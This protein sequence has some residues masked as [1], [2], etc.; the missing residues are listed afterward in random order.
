MAFSHYKTY[1]TMTSKILHVRIGR[2]RASVA[3]GL[4]ARRQDFDDRSLPASTGS[5]DKTASA[6]HRTVQMLH[7]ESAPP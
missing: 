7:A 1:V 3:V 6:F 5:R 4:P 2:G